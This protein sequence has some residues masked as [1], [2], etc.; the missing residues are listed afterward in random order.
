MKVLDKSQRRLLADYL[1]NVSAGW[2]LLG[3]ISPFMTNIKIDLIILVNVFLSL[4]FSIFI[5]GIG[6]FLVK[7]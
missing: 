2:F 7:N 4:I 6:I 3:V 1:N 5:I